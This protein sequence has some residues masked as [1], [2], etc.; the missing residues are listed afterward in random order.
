MEE[1][2]MG[3]IQAITLILTITINHSFLALPKAIINST[4]SAAI[5]NVLYIGILAIL[6]ALLISKLLSNFSGLDI[7]DIS[8]FLGGKFLKFAIGFMFLI[9]LI[10]ISSVLLKDFSNCLQVI[11]YPMT[12][13][14]F[15][16]ILFIIAVAVAC[17]LK[18]NSALKSNL[19]V[20]PLVLLSMI[21]LFIANSKYFNFENVFPI[22]GNGFSSI[23]LSGTSNLYAFG[24]LACIYLLPS[25]LMEPKKIKRISVVST[26]L[27][28]IYLLLSI[29]TLLFMFHSDALANEMSPLYSAVRYI[30]FG[31]FFQRLDSAFLL[32]WILSFGCY[33]CIITSFALRVFQKITNIKNDKKVIYPFLITVLGFGLMQKSTSVTNFL[34]TTVFKYAF[35]GFSILIC[36]TILILANFKKRATRKII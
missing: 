20:I 21:F 16:M 29:S 10:I 31:T 3:S 34:E 28:L 6:L 30:E 18:N 8:N 12:D 14:L 27:S 1:T 13:L 35:F 15:I 36:L 5:L 25:T 33:L 7:L 32:I 17:N 4:G 23:F 22:L 24:G 9:Y 26:V 11:Y 2:K 19:I